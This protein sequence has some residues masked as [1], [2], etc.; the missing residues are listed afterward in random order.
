MASKPGDQELRELKHEPVPGYGKAFAI[1][2]A[3]MA[4][5]LA[6]ILI[7]SPG[8]ATGHGLGDSPGKDNKAHSPATESTHGPAADRPL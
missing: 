8:P 6:I 5:Y 4:I 2:F 1:A 7:S 3:I